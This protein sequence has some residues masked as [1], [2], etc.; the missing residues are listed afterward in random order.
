MTLDEAI[1]HCKEVADSVCGECA[2]EHKQLAMWLEELKE[3]R[4]KK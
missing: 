2:D 3:L 4:E 1:A